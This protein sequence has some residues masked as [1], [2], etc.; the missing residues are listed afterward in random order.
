MALPVPE[1]GLVI[2]YSYLWR[3]EA[4]RGQEEGLKDRPC[5]VVLASAQKSSGET[6]VMVAAITHSQ[7]SKEARAIEV[8]L[9]VGQHL[10]FDAARSWIITSEVNVF[11]WPGPDLR[12]QGPGKFAFGHLPRSL[13]LKLRDTIIEQGR[14]R[15][16]TVERDEQE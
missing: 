5:A 4:Q 8:P 2:R 10:G 7:P 9:K 12:A 11:T 6:R 16:R 13:A 14:E 15:S 1:P 3:S